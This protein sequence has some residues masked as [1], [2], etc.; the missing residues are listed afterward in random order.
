[1]ATTTWP[2]REVFV[3]IQPR[4]DKGAYARQRDTP[5][6]QSA[7]PR[8]RSATNPVGRKRQAS[9][10]R[11]VFIPLVILRRRQDRGSAVIVIDAMGQRRRSP[12]IFRAGFVGFLI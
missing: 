10:V 7:P 12:V 4:Q 11:D 8:L 9:C 1:M 6:E 5:A 3:V 2:S